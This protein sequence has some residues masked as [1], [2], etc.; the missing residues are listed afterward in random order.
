MSK[1]IQRRRGSTAE[2]ASFTG[3]AGELTVDT[4]KKTVVV[5][6]G[7]TAGGTPLAKEAHSHAE[8]SDTAAGML[9]VATAAEI[10]NNGT[11]NRALVTDQVWSSASPVN[12]G[13]VT[14]NVTLTF[15]NFLNA[16]ATQTGN[17]TLNAVSGLKQGQTAVIEFFQDATGG[18]TISLNSSVFVTSGA[19]SITTTANARNVLTFY[20]LSDGKALVCVAG[21]G[22]A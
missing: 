10:R 14:G 11:A 12:L 2:H 20:G 15:S 8:G 5:H 3:A 4:T 6:D 7:T 17:V 22:V 18:R 13:N 9:E 19:I 21:K 1:Q 16:K